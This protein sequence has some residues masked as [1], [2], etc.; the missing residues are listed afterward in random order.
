MKI[1]NLFSFVV[2]S[3]LAAITFAAGFFNPVHFIF[4]AISGALAS[5][6]MFSHDTEDG[7]SLFQFLRGLKE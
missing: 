2:F 1:F 5:L 3:G 7:E 4:S 6:A